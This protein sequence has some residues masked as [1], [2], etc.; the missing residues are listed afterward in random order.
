MFSEDYKL[1]WGSRCGFAKVAKEAGVP[2]IPMFTTNLQH[3]MPLFGFN[4]SATMKKWYAS[5]RFPLSIP[6][7]YFPVKMRTYLGEPLYCDT[8]EE[9]EVF[10]LRCKKAIENLRDK[11]Q[12]PQQSYWN[13]LRERL[14]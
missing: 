1:E 8:D 3:S 9:P 2:V 12:P 11:Y 6:K 10:A 4:K 13:A 5:T 7:A 14:W